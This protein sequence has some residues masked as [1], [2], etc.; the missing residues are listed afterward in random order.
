MT[1]AFSSLNLVLLGPP[2]SGKSTQARVLAAN[3]SVPHIS[4]Y[5]MLRT[6]IERASVVGRKAEKLVERGEL[7]PD[8][9]LA[10]LILGR[11][12]R[13]DCARGMILD[14]YPRTV[15]Q[16]ALL[17]GIL[18]ELG[19][20]IERVVLF[21]MSVEAAV[22]RLLDVGP[23]ARVD[24]EG[25]SEV[26][27]DAEEWDEVV[28]E[29]ARVWESKSPKLLDFYRNRGLLMEIAADRPVAEVTEAVLR[30]VGAPVGA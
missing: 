27:L 7:V 4:T 23:S 19:R 25:G 16:A 29:R 5:E 2:G 11:L 20:S 24:R 3:Y 14:G 30:T 22:A 10:G 18:A 13:D 15:D 17:D 12:D 6:E 28:R 8:K 21:S 9:V 1:A 26:A